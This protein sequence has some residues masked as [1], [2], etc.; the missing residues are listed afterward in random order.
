MNRFYCSVTQHYRYFPRN[1]WKI[2]NIPQIMLG[3]HYENNCL[4]LRELETI[5]MSLPMR[6]L[7]VYLILGLRQEMAAGSE[8]KGLEL[9]ALCVSTGMKD[10]RPKC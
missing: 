2:K 7:S 1:T 9:S 8:L 4:A 5:A 3:S 6:S 10:L